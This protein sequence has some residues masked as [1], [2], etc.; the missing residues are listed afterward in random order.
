M[1]GRVSNALW[2]K[3]PGDLLQ[4]CALRRAGL[5]CSCLCNRIRVLIVNARLLAFAT[6]RLNLDLVTSKLYKNQFA[7]R[8][9]AAMPTPVL[10]RSCQHGDLVVAVA[11]ITNIAKFGGVFDVWVNIHCHVGKRRAQ[12]LTAFSHSTC[13]LRSGDVTWTH[14]AALYS[15]HAHP[16]LNMRALQANLGL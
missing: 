9:W 8:R 16:Y 11:R 15:S 1:W 12:D 3:V 7:R 4:R 5:G 6:R 14:T 2:D 13:A 10:D